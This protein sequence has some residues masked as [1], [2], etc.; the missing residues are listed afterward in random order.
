MPA[1]LAMQ[2]R[3]PDQACTG[4][5]AV[6]SAGGGHIT[7]ENAMRLLRPTYRARPP[8]PNPDKAPAKESRP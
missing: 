4:W 7:R 1:P 5:R 6:V 8:R 2:C 3:C